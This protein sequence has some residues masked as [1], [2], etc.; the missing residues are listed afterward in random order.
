MSVYTCEVIEDEDGELLIELPEGM[1]EK[2][3]WKV[4]DEIVWTVT[5][6]GTAHI[7]LKDAA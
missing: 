1:L 4:G 7:R 2:V 5:G 6:D 3:G